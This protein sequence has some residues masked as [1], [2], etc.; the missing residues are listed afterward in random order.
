MI[1][2]YPT[3]EM[4]ELDKCYNEMIWIWVLFIMGSVMLPVLIFSLVNDW[5]NR[6]KPKQYILK[7]TKNPYR[8]YKKIKIL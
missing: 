8:R 4:S 7:R 6:D 3:H 5:K 1:I 2:I